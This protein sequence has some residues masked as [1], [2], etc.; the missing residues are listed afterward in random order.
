MYVDVFH[1]KNGKES[2]HVVERDKEGKRVFKQFDPEWSLYY[3]DEDGKH[4]SIYEDKLS[5]FKGKKADFYKEKMKHKQVYES[6]VPPLFK[7]MEKYYKGADAPNP[8][9]CFFDIEVD[10]DKERGY[11]MPE[12]P[13][14][15][16]TAISFY[17]DW[18]DKC[19]TLVQAPKG[20]AKEEAEAICAGFPD[21]YL[22]EDEK[23]ILSVFV[24]M[25]VDA[26][27]LTGWNSDT[28]DIPY[29]IGRMVRVLGRDSPKKLCL[30]DQMPIAKTFEKFGKETLTYSLIGRIHLDY[31]ELY[32]KFTFSELHSY[33]L[34]VVGDFE[35]KERKVAYDGTL[36]ELYNNDFKKFVDYSRQDV[37]LMTKIDAKLRFIDL[38][39]AMAHE[40]CVLLP[41]TLGAVH[42]SD[43]AIILETHDRGYVVNDRVRETGDHISLIDNVVE[44]KVN[45]TKKRKKKLP[46]REQATALVNAK[47]AGAYVANPKKGLSK[48]VGSV[49]ITSLYP[50]I[51][52]ALNISPETIKG[53]I[54]QDG[55]KNEII[56]H[57]MNE[58]DDEFA[59]AW[60]GRFSTLEFE[61]M[62]SGED[63]IVTVS[64]EHAKKKQKP[65]TLAGRDLKKMLY[66]S[67]NKTCVSA[68]GT[69]FST[70]KEGVIPG[71]I[72]RWFSER[73]TMKAKKAEYEDALDIETDKEKLKDLKAKFT[74][75]DQRQHIKKIQL[76]SLYGALTNAGSR[77]YDQRMGQ[78]ITLT[79]RG[80]ARHMAGTINEIITGVFDHNGEA[81]VYGDTDS[82]YFSA[83]PVRDMFEGFEFNEQSVVDLYDEVAKQTNDTF[84]EF[85]IND[86]NADPVR[87]K[88]IRADREICASSALFVKKKRYAAKV[89]NKDGYP[90]NKI[91]IMGMD[92]QRADTPKFVQD[93]LKKI[94]A[95]TLDEA[96]EDQILTFV[97][98]F[99]DDFRKLKPWEMGI[100]RRV[101]KLTH[102]TEIENDKAGSRLPGHVRGAYNWNKTKN[103]MEDKSAVEIYDGGKVVV[104]DL[105]NN[106]LT[107][108]SIAYP[109]DENN[110]PEWF[111]MLPFDTEKMEEK[112][113]D[114]KLDNIVGLMNYNIETTKLTIDDSLFD[115]K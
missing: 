78:S 50:S 7:L 66:G 48:W 56:E 59:A 106:N 35:V 67:H 63:A 75:W 96:P 99:R 74:F 42:L 22:C 79:G 29:V 110:L 36:D 90:T 43:H 102:Y 64:F 104:C 86:Y 37:M 21:T 9:I 52:M 8:H 91:K 16:I 80:I 115:M 5:F 83:W 20:M 68:N 111:T 113:I 114:K 97:K 60:S 26:D 95:M 85:M 89:Y 34:D 105:K 19:Y 62:F 6:D 72:A 98:S 54:H 70:D 33:A 77:F 45:N 108:T 109:I 27:I 101:N 81:I 11:A 14:N 12:D 13:F 112:L 3:P 65:R 41:K 58:G 53:Q 87:A 1:N 76:N 51:I 88:R 71:L 94:L 46:S 92:T 23:T 25:I 107:I 2:I 47:I 39:N 28:Y 103:L 44:E 93:F 69:I 49:D 61:Q 24:D 84:A 32:R 4:R 38:V 100:P 55:T 30:W 82:A 15:E 73:E 17:N 57:M 40:N 18:E 10:F 31:L